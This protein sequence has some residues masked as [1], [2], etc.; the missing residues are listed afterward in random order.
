M[1]A[2]R[3][4]DS[5]AVDH[6]TRIAELERQVATLTEQHASAVKELEAFA[7]A[8][9]HDLRAPLRSLSGFSQAL[10]E[11]LDTSDEKNRH[12]LERIKQASAKMSELIDALLNLSRI[13]RAD[14]FP[15]DVDLTQLCNDTASAVRANAGSRKFKITIAPQLQTIGDQR[16]LRTVVENLVDNA[17]KF[18]ARESETVIDI[19][20]TSD[21]AFY[22]RD[23]GV[24]FD[25]AHVDKL[26]KPFQRLHSENDFPGLGMGLATVQRIV[27]RHGG[28]CWINAAP[29]AGATAFFVLGPQGKPAQA[30]A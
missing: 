1:N 25:M 29:H 8:V 2:E 26:F 4:F 28:R 16:L 7:Y 18:S 22:I 19:G 30:S 6:A 21:G 12:Y 3:H 14:L 20:R 17:V 23:H 9:S 24:G 11:S 5:A 27:A 15:R 13:A 10:V